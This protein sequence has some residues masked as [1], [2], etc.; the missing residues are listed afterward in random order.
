MLLVAEVLLM[1]QVL[2]VLEVP[3]VPEVPL[4]YPEGSELF[5][6]PA[7]E[8]AAAATMAAKRNTLERRRRAF[9][10]ERVAR[11]CGKRR[12]SRLMCGPQALRWSC[13]IRQ[14]WEGREGRA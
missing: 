2:F 3:L 4:L 6:H 8:L 5:A 14:G 7:P 13:S 1:G 9:R 11:V 10:D 12:G